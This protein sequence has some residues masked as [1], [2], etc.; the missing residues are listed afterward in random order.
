[1]ASS[2]GGIPM[3]RAVPDMLRL[4]AVMVAVLMLVILFPDT[5]LAPT[6]WLAF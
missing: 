6:R 2:I 4:L 5:A 3:Q 1:V